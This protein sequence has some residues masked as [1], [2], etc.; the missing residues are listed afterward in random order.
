MSDN[1]IVRCGI[2]PGIGIARVGNS[3]T[4]YFVGPESPG[5]TPSP[6]ADGYKDAQGRIKRQAARFRIYGLNSAGAFVKELTADDADITWT[7]H[8]ANKKAAWYEFQIALDIPEAKTSAAPSRRR[9]A[10]YTGGNRRK[11]I[12]DPGPRS[13][14][15]K[16]T[17]GSQYHFDTGTFL[18]HKVPLGEIRTGASGNLLVLG[19]MGNSGTF[20]AKN[21]AHTFGNNDGWYDDISDGPVTARVVIG[22]KSLP[23]TPAWVIVAPPD[24][25]PGIPSIVTLYDIVWQAYLDTHPRS[26]PRTVSFTRHI[27]PIFQRFDSFQWVNRGFY[28][29]YGWKGQVPLLDPA[30]L[31]KLASN[32]AANASERQKIFDRFRNPSY[33]Q[34]QEDAW[35]RLYGD[36]FDQP[37][38]DGRQYLTVT[39]EQY[40]LLSKW[41]QG[42]FVADWNPSTM[43]PPRPLQDLPV[44]QRPHALDEA[45]LAACLGGPFHPGCEATWP[46]RHASMYSGLCR[47]NM[48]Q[49]NDP[50]PDYGDVL[51]P[52]EV[53]GTNGPLHKS[54]PGD[55]SRWMAIPWQ[56]DTSSCGSAY[57]NSTVQPYPLPDLPSFWP[58]R[59]PNAILTN[60]MYQRVLNTGLSSAQ[61]HAA[62]DTRV[63]WSRNIP[64]FNYYVARINKF[65]KEWYKAGIVVRR[66]GPVHDSSFPSEMHVEMESG[67]PAST[68]D[69]A[70]DLPAQPLLEDWRAHR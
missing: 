30:Y 17:S 59:V 45:A 50:E 68:L 46:L 64:S 37:P 12:I 49:S 19:G 28:E 36:N 23:V 58:A 25:A 13:I 15:G 52:T 54:A 43:K 56:T 34:L 8:L 70:T 39:R 6:G 10:S 69:Q 2:H 21:P 32:S 11:L 1:E 65:V 67:Y 4:E 29:G 24:Y 51:T 3:P 33:S 7:V 47:L 18:G 27:Y 26:A 60:Q 14:K 38:Q 42:Q 31:A 41:A 35:P 66:P 61:R 9:N 53:L 63:Q 40:R 57:P 20:E 22:G 62:F 5:V 16:S 48:R 44:S 55:I